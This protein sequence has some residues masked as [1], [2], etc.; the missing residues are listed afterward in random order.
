[1]PFGTSHKARFTLLLSAL[2]L[3]AETASSGTLRQVLAAKNLPIAGAKLENLDK[4]ITGG[5]EL[6][7]GNLKE[8]RRFS[9][10]IRRSS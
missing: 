9:L 6:D 4:N 3:V 7:G 1:M 5:A 2:C 10:T 8:V